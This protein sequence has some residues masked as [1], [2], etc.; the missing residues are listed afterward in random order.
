MLP[1]IPLQAVLLL[2]VTFD[3]F[4]SWLRQSVF[5]ARDIWPEPNHSFSEVFGWL[6]LPLHWIYYSLLSFLPIRGHSDAWI[7]LAPPLNRLG[8]LLVVPLIFA[9]TLAGAYFLGKWL[10]KSRWRNA[11]FIIAAACFAWDAVVWSHATYRG[12]KQAPALRARKNAIAGCE[13][14]GASESRKCHDNCRDS[15]PNLPPPSERTETMMK[16]YHQRW[17]ACSS[18]CTELGNG[19][20]QNCLKNTGYPEYQN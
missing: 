13:E 1:R 11:V 2:W 10:Q 9:T 4:R 15:L 17:D 14:K 8:S 3:C 16:E 20:Q 6:R 12:W 18:G 19:F 7:V 5:L